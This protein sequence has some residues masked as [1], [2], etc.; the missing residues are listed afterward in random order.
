[1][2]PGY[3]SADDWA[4]LGAS[5]IILFN[6][7]GMLRGILG[8]F[9][10]EHVHEDLIHQIEGIAQRVQGVERIAKCHAR[11]SGMHFWVDMHANVNGELSVDE[12]H[13][14]ANA[15]EASVCGEIPEVAQVLVHIKPSPEA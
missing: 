2:G 15:I 5:G 10:D 7:Y 11:K 8:E 4:A 14:I 6:A 1:M 3:E 12:G 9:M 13:E